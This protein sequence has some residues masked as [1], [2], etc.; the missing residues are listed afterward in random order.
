MS[1]IKLSLRDPETGKFKEHVQTFIPLRK[2]VEYIQKEKALGEKYDDDI[3]QEEL[4]DMRYQFIAD[5]FDDE[6]VTKEYI[7]DGL[8]ASEE[9]VVLDIILEHVLSVDTSERKK[10]RAEAKKK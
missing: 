4:D 1:E 7:L 2:K 6:K 9:H 10:Q 5:L 8:V 3:P